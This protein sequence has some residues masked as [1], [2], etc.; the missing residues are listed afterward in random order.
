MDR[1]PVLVFDLNRPVM[2]HDQVEVEIDPHAVGGVLVEVN[3][4]H[5]YGWKVSW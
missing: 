2:K 3:G 1:E 5:L 4:D